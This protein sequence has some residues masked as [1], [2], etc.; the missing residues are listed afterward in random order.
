MTTL[1]INS[2]MDGITLDKP[3]I[4]ISTSIYVIEESVANHPVPPV[5]DLSRKS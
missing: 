2:C 1:I 5:G 4:M 3:L